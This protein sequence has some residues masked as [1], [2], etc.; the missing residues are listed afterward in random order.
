MSQEP[1]V[2][3]RGLKACGL[4]SSEDEPLTLCHG[5]TSQTVLHLSAG[6][7]LQKSTRETTLSDLSRRMNCCKEP[8]QAVTVNR[9]Q[10]TEVEVDEECR[11]ALSKR[12]S[13]NQ[14]SDVLNLGRHD[15][16][17]NECN[18]Q[19]RCDPANFC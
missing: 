8:L 3:F 19:D 10:S 14:N 18:Y 4:F 7:S 13:L 6:K 11:N 9:L 15:V 1:A 2:F 17:E 12:V 16:K 5:I